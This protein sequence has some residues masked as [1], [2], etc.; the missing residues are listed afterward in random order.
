MA[1]TVTPTRCVFRIYPAGDVIALLLDLEANPGHVVCY[2]HIGQHGEASYPAVI[3]QT[4]P[5]KVD[6][7]MPLFREL[8]GRGYAIITRKRRTIQGTRHTETYRA[9]KVRP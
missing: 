8:Q 2:Q 3:A 9:H 4:T 1:E 7:Y 5:A 6:Q